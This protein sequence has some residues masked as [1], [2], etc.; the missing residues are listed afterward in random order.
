MFYD[1]Y[2]NIAA[3]EEPNLPSARIGTPLIV[4]TIWGLHLSPHISVSSAI[5]NDRIL[6]FNGD[7]RGLLVRASEAFANRE[8]RV[9]DYGINTFVDLQLEDIRA[10]N[11]SYR[12]YIQDIHT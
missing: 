5:R 7:G 8:D 4:S 12:T 10:Q 3:V 6:G 2:E 1:G 9:N 11:L